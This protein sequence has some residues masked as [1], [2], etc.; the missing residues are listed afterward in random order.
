MPKVARNIVLAY[1]FANYFA[2]SSLPKGAVGDSP[3]AA[4]VASASD[5]WIVGA[6]VGKWIS[7]GQGGQLIGEQAQVLI[8]NVTR[9]VL[10]LPRNLR[11]EI[12][13]TLGDCRLDRGLTYTLAGRVL[14]IP[15]GTAQSTFERVRSRQWEPAGAVVSILQDDEDQAT[16]EPDTKATDHRR[17]LLNTVRLI[18]GC[19][20]AGES[21][22]QVEHAIHRVWL[23]GGLVD[24]KLAHK[25]FVKEVNALARTVL[26]CADADDFNAELPGLGIWYMDCAT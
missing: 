22:H 19:A 8:T 3:D 23:A 9:N 6:N 2:R 24:R 14:G 10:K 26:A 13:D 11:R 20:T 4:A 15:A 7:R 12:R 18:I 25:D 17:S 16:L 21:Y 5:K 1:R